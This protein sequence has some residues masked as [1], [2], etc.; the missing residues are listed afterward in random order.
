MASEI[1]ERT[2]EIKLTRGDSLSV[3]IDLYNSAGEVYT[4]EEGDRI[5]FALK[6]SDIR[7]DRKGFKDED[8]LIEKSIPIDT[9]TLELAPT[10]TKSLA[11]ITYAYDIEMTFANGRVDTFVQNAKF[12]IMPEVH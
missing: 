5:R 11:F 10:D 9:L 3:K 1:N 6:R 7:N 4:P 2:N 8:P 12:T